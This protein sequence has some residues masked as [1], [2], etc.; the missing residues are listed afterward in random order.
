MKS[1]HV[2][3]SSSNELSTPESGDSKCKQMNK[4]SVNKK[5]ISAESWKYSYD[6]YETHKN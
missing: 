4:N 1:V 5:M 6:C 2:M 3:Q